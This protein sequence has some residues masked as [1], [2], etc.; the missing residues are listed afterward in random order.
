LYIEPERMN[1]LDVTNHND[2]Q[3]THRCNY[4]V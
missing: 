3:R 4:N 2:T 1:S